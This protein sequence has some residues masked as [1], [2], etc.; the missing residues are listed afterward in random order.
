MRA[1]G[2]SLDEESGSEIVFAESA[3][4]AWEAFACE[5]PCSLDAHCSCYPGREVTPYPGFDQYAPGP[6]P[7]EA[8][9]RG[10]WAMR[11]RRCDEAGAYS[12]PSGAE[13]PGD[14]AIVEIDGEGV[15]LCHECIREG[16]LQC[17]TL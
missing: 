13:L 16:G 17:R 1:W 9:L 6:V 10:G 7:L 5:D 2:V 8:F 11:C 4:D 14:W 12:D 15:P 3:E